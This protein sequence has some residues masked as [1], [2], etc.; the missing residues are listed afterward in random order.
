MGERTVQ[1]PDSVDSG[2]LYIF[3]ELDL[4]WYKRFWHWFTRRPLVTLP[5]GWKKIGRDAYMKEPQEPQP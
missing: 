3:F 5:K 2:P 1:F 4:P